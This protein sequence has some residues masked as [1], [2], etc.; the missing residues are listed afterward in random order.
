VLCHVRPRGGPHRGSAHTVTKQP[1]HR[2]SDRGDVTDWHDD[3]R[4]A[5]HNR[6]VDAGHVGRHDWN[7]QRAR[8]KGH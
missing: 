4:H 6:V 1:E 7:S 2:A 8:L 5:V 3:S